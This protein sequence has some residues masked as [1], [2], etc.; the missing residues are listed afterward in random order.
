MSELYEQLSKLS[1]ERRVLLEKKLAE[2]GIVSQLR[3]QIQK[4]EPNNKIPLSFAQQ[5]LWFVQQLSPKVTTYNVTSVLLLEGDLNVP[6]MQHALHDLV[7]RHEIL[8]T[9][10]IATEQASKAEQI[11]NPV[12]DVETTLPYIDYSSEQDPASVSDAYIANLINRAFDLS[13]VP[14]RSALIKLGADRHLI[15]LVTH[16]IVSDRWS[17]GIFLREL[18]TL[19]HSNINDLEAPLPELPI[20][21]GD[22]A[23]WQ[24]QHL[25]GIT[26]NKLQNYWK[27]QLTNEY[28]L[29]DLPVDF[30]RPAQITNAG[31]QFPLKISKK[32]SSKLRE[33]AKQ[34]KVT[35]FQLLLTNL[36]ILLYRYTGNKQIRVG[37]DIA[38][39]DQ[40]E[41]ESLIGLLVNTLVLQSELD[42][43]ESFTD[44][45]QQVKQ[46]M[47]DAMEHQA[48][49]FEQVV[50]LVKPERHLDQLMP[51]F[52][53]KL[54][55]QLARV[56]KVALEGLSFTV[57]TPQDTS[58]KYELR[59]NLQ[60]TED[61]INGQIEYSTDLFKQETIQDIAHHFVYLLEQTVKAPKENISSYSLSDQE[62]SLVGDLTNQSPSFS[63]ET[64]VSLVN[65]TCLRSPDKIAASDPQQQ[66]T[67]QELN[68]RSSHLAK[69][70][71][72][73]GIQTEQAVGIL[74]SRSVDILIAIL[75]VLKSDGCYVPLDPDY[76]AAR[77]STI[78]DD[79][80]IK[81]MLI[82]EQVKDASVIQDLNSIHV[83]QINWESRDQLSITLP[84]PIPEQLAYII[85][86]SGS[87]G[88]PK[89]VAIEH[90]NT[91]AMLDWAKAT[92]ST[93]DL[94]M[95]LASTSICFDLSVYELFLPLVCGTHVHIVPN[96][97]SL[98]EPEIEQNLTLINTVPSVLS[99]VIN[100][101]SIP[102]SIK[103][104]NLAGEPLTTELIKQLQALGHIERVYNLYGPSEDT[105]YSTWACFDLTQAI[106]DSRV[107][108]GIPITGTHAY[109]LDEQLKVVPDGI[110]G[111]LYLSG[112]GV[113]R[114]Y[115]GQPELTQQQFIDNPF[116]PET[117]YA[118]RLYAT[119][120]RVRRRRDGVLEYQ[121]RIDNQVKIRGYRIEIGEIEAT[122]SQYPDTITV[123]VLSKKS[124]NDHSLIA[125]LE[126]SSTQKP[127][128]SHLREFLQS[129]IPAWSIPSRFILVDTMPR[130]PNGKIN[131][132][133]LAQLSIPAS[134]KTNYEAPSTPIEKQLA[135][136][137]SRLIGVDQIS[138]NDNFFALGG[139]S[140]MALDLINQ[141]QIELNCQ[142]PLRTLFETTNLAAFGHRVEEIIS[143]HDEQ[144]PLPSNLP[145]L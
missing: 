63:D 137:W 46:T 9:C 128:Q 117:S 8:R 82:D 134:T 123:T 20:Q 74:M 16:H 101:A 23:H 112:L 90:R 99:K 31:A 91:V 54:D 133:A 103:V 49:P 25:Q 79:A 7:A 10:F 144:S 116:L 109:V 127:E 19:Y 26:L 40:I 57:Q 121:G 65:K 50:E 38:N 67:Y 75:A 15:V 85:Y 48:L 59:L 136:I 17:V 94:A 135:N 118:T 92:Y 71:I 104:V 138:L 142:I 4:R 80:D 34:Q 69:I 83:N 5:R 98:A 139:H 120:D 14:F 52:Q 126:S 3:W 61:G 13:Q 47:M 89:G 84:I 1:P 43:E 96:A 73:E 107:P 88:K 33:F 28:N 125:Y 12:P 130:L 58:S 81:V 106:P 124:D 21:Y 62:S 70:L 56:E 30:S 35:L 93:D 68:D 145:T 6:A 24:R 77:L 72:C 41:T 55:L 11:V 78:I 87:T 100:Q 131:R 53:V 111:Q 119:G 95:V 32:L 110:S 115:H 129:R 45:L 97:L 36:K 102:R 105:T 66:I 18:A 39:R 42:P 44:T 37:T 76:P 22:Y 114:G 122:L 29:L 141:C 86:T 108:I 64:L 140:L 60:D 113:A 143:A 132:K 27:Q 2:K 51:L